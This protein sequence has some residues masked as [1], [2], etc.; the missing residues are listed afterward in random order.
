MSDS[1]KVLSSC[2]TVFC[3]FF[4]FTLKGTNLVTAFFFLNV[5]LLRRLEKVVGSSVALK[6]AC[7]HQ[8]EALDCYQSGLHAERCVSTRNSDTQA[9]SALVL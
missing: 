2:A 7:S 4:F 3:C 6:P 1:E 5:Q 9:G 8:T